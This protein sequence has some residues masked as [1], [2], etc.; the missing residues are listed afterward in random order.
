MKRKILFIIVAS[1]LT[2]YA[3]AIPQRTIIAGDFQAALHLDADQKKAIK[4]DEK[5]IYADTVFADLDLD[6]L[7][8]RI[9][10]ENG[11]HIAY[12]K[13]DSSY[14]TVK[15]SDENGKI[16]VYDLNEDKLPDIIQQNGLSGPLFYANTGMKAMTSEMIPI[17]EDSETYFAYNNYSKNS[18]INYF[19]SIDNKNITLKIDSA[20]VTISPGENWFGTASLS[21][22]YKNENLRDTAHFSIIVLSQNDA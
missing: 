8:D 20:G 9:T 13:A 10:R 7:V 3:L 16:A 6:G 22:T 18:G 17:S 1:L 12:Q 21:I 15:L 11:L 14:R 5:I 4:S 2:A 19:P